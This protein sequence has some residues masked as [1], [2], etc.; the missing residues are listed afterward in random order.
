[1]VGRWEFS[2]TGFTTLDEQ[3]RNLLHDGATTQS[4]DPRV[5][6]ETVGTSGRWQGNL[7]A[8]EHVW[9]KLEDFERFGWLSM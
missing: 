6:T 5:P 7:R 3:V 9:R 2:P 1:M 8:D 4:V